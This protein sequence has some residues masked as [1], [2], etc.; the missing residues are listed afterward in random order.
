MKIILLAL[1]LGAI[2]TADAAQQKTIQ[3]LKRT[4]AVEY[5]RAGAE[6]E[7]KDNK[8]VKSIKPKPNSTKRVFGADIVCND[9]TQVE[10]EYEQVD[11]IQHPR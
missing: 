8:G 5:Y 10:I 1:A 3:E 4:E 6:K 2:S 7:C 9:L 11:D